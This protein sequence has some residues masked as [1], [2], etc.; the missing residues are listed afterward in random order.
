MHDVVLSNRINILEFSASCIAHQRCRDLR[1]RC[2]WLMRQLK[3][4]LEFNELDGGR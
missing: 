3:P 1:L 2:P 4:A